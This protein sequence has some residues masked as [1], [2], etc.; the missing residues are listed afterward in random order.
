[1]IVVASLL[2]LG[3][4]I[5]DAIR[6]SKNKNALDLEK[7]FKILAIFVCNSLKCRFSMLAHIMLILLN[8]NGMGML[9][10]QS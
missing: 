6:S 3:F 8:K 10:G 1:M 7:I 4:L 5:Y 2:L 9:F